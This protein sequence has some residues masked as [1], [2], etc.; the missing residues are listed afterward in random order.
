M[1]ILASAALVAA[2][3]LVATQP[4]LAAELGRD[5]QS[6]MGMF[7]GVQLNVPFG[8]PRAEGTRAS[9]AVAPVMRSQRMDGAAATRI[10]RGLE[11]SFG[12][13]QPEL[14]LAGTRLDRLDTLGGAAGPNGR[15]AN[16]TTLGWVGI[17]VGAV[18]LVLG[19]AYLWLD[20]ALDCDPGEECS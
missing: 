2:Q 17:G 19:G 16:I 9:L 20:E 18:A 12:A 11:L 15:R 4:A 13:R 5:E 7:G 14:R 8:G 6:R 1:K 3:L 10:G